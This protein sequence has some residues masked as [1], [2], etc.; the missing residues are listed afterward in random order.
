LLSNLT[1][2]ALISFIVSATPELNGTPWS[3][4]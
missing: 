2:D 3:R 4:G 1:G